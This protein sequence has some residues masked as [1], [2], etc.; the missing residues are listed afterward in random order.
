[1]EV[2]APNRYRK[3]FAEHPK[4]AAQYASEREASKQM[5]REEWPDRAHLARGL[6]LNLAFEPVLVW[7][8]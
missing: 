3:L 1:M 4:S 5:Q 7:E 6:E 2:I 8:D